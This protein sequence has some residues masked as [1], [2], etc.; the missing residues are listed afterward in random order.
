MVLLRDGATVVQQVAGCIKVSEPVTFSI[1]LAL[2]LTLSGGV[3]E[4]VKRN[5]VV[6]IQLTGALL[7]IIT[8]ILI[9]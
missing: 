7:T 2:L 3:G 4:P 1:S 9:N 5:D 8:I 6:L